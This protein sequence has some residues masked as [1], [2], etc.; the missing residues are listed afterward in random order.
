MGSLTNLASIFTYS[1]RPGD[2]APGQAWSI[3]VLHLG[4]SRGLTGFGLQVRVGPGSI[5]S[6]LSTL[7]V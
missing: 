7:S 3:P 4:L 2:R 1:R 5:P 6:V